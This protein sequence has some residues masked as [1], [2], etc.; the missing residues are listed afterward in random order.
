MKKI[1]TSLKAA[2]AVCV[3][4]TTTSLTA[5]G[6]WNGTGD[7]LW[8]NSANWSV[9]PYPLGNDTASFINAGN[10]QNIDIAGLAGI[11]N[12]TFDSPLVAAYTNGT[13]APNS[14]TL[15]LAD[16]GTITLTGTALNSQLF[17]CGL[18]LGTTIGAGAY[19]L[20]NGNMAQTLTF[21]NVFAPAGGAA[22]G[23]K[24]LAINGAGNTTILGNISKGGATSL[25]LTH[26]SSG[27]LTL[28]GSNVITT[29]TMNGGTNSVIDIGSGTLF[30]NNLGTIVLNCNQGGVINGT[31]K[32][33]LSTVDGFNN[34][35][36]NYADLN[37]AA[38]KTLVI[39]PEITGLGGFE[40]NTGTGTFVLNGMN[41]F[42]GHIFLNTASPISVFRIGNRG[43]VDSNLGKGSIIYFN[44][45]AKLIYTGT[46]ET[47]DR[48]IILNNTG[49]IDQSGP[50]GKLS[51]SVSP[52]ILG[53]N[54]TLILQ[55]STACS[56]E[57]TAPLVN[58]GYTLTVTKAGS[59]TWILSGTN[60]YTGNT[61]VNGG[62]LLVNA[63]GTST[64]SSITVNNGAILGGNSTINGNVTL[65]AGGMLAPGD[66]GTVGT[67]NLGG[68][69]T[70]T[71]GTLLF[72]VSN[73]ATDKVSVVGALTVNG[74]NTVVLSFPSGTLPAGTNT[75]MTFA[76]RTG[77]GTFVLSPAY[78]NATLLTN[79]TSVQ[80]VVSDTGTYSKIWKG[81][82]SGNWNTTE[83]NWTN[84]SAAV[85]FVA[86]DA[87]LFD[88]SAL[89]FNVTSSSPVLPSAVLFNNNVSNYVLSAAMAGTGVVFKTGS[90]NVT[91]S[92]TNTF[93]G[94]TTIVAGTLTI[95]ETGVLGNGNYATNI[96]N[97]GAVNYASSIAQTNSGVISGGG[98][99]TSSGSGTLTLLGANTYAGPT[100][101][102]AGVL[103][104]QNAAGLGTTAE[105]TTVA[106]GAKLE[107][108]GNITTLG[109]TLN[110][111]GTLASQTGTNTYAGVVSLQAGSFLDV[112]LNSLLI[113]TANTAN[114]GV[115]PFSKTGAGTLRL[116]GDPNHLGVFTVSAGTLELTGGGNA[117]D[118]FVID[119]G[120]TLM[121]TTANLGD[122]RLT[123]NGLFD[124]RATDQ[125]GGLDGS[126]IVTIGNTTAYTFTVGGNN[127]SGVFSGVM[128][129]GSGTLSFAKVQTGIQTL[130]GASTYSGGTTLSGGQLNINNGGS[131]GTSSAIGT[132]AFTISGAYTIDN[133]SGA[134]V[135]LSPVIAQS[136]NGSFTFVGSKSLN[137]GTGAVTMNNNRAV[138]VLT[139][140]LTVGGAIGGGAYSLTKA[141]AGT[142]TLSGAN[143]YS[144]A[145]IVN[146]G[147]LIINGS[148]VAA[149]AV[150]VN[151][152]TILGGSG[153]I[154][155]TV[156]VAAGGILAPG[157]VNATNTL[158]LTNTGNALTLTN[159]VLLFDLPASGT[160]CDKINITGATGKL[161]LNGVNKIA[162]SFP[163]G[164]AQAG[165]YILMTCTGGIT[166]NSGVGLTLQTVYPGATLNM[167]GNNL[168]LTLGS[169]ISGVT[170]KG[171]LSDVWD[172]GILNWTTN[173][174]VAASYTAGNVVTF[175]DTATGNFS[176]S[177]VGTVSP[178]SVLFNNSVNDYF[179]TADLSGTG[180]LV[181]WGS[182]T[183]TLLSG[184]ST[185]NPISITVNDGTLALG[186]A[187]RL[188]SGVY[189]GNILNNGMLT[190]ASSVAQTNS[191]ILSG[192]GTL[193]VSGSGTLTLSGTNTYTGSTIVNA[194][195]TLA[196]AGNISTPAGA[197]LNLFGTLSSPTGSNTYVGAVSFQTGSA[198]DVGLGSILTLS[199]STVLVAGYPPFTKT[200]AGL[201][202]LMTD[203]NHNGTMTINGGAVELAGA[204]TDGDYVIN[205]G[206]TLIESIVN[207]INDN[208]SVT[209]NAG[210]FYDL[211]QN[212]TIASFSGA[213]TVTKGTTGGATL[214][215]GGNNQSCTFSGVIENGLGMLSYVKTG[216][217][218]QTLTGMNSYTGTT[219][220][221]GG[222]LLVNSPGSLSNSTVTVNAACTLGGNGSINGNVIMSTG[223]ILAPGG[224]NAFG[225]LTLGR[226]LTLNGNTLFFDVSS[227]ATEQVVVTGVLTNKGVNTI[228]LSFP[229]GALPAADYTL[230]TFSSKVDTGSFV[231]LGSY[232]N[233]SLVFVGNSLVLRVSGDGTSGLTWNGNVSASWDGSDKNW[234][235]GTS[236]TNFAAG[237]AVTFDDTASSFNVIS[238]GVVTPSS[239]FFNNNID[240]PYF[241]TANIDGTALLLKAGPGSTTL[242]ALSTYNPTSI[243]VNA[244]TL[245]LAGASQL[246]S[247]NCS[248]PI[249]INSGTFNHSSSAAQILSGIISGAGSVV[250][251]VSGSLTLSN[252]NTYSGNTTLSGGTLYGAN[253][254]AFGTAART[255]S[256]GGGTLDLATDTSINA[257]N[258]TVTASTTI[259]SD[260]ATASSA[261]IT[262][263]LG[264]LST[265]NF[266]LYVKS[267][268]NVSANSSYGLTFGNT[269]L[270]ANTPTFDVAN[271][272]TGL[273][274][275]TLGA[276]SNNNNFNKANS[277]TLFLGTTSARAG[278]TA[279]ITAGTLKLGHASALG[280]TAALLA[281]NGGTLDLAIDT[282][283]NAHPTTVGGNTTIQSDKAT[284]SSAGITHTLGTLS[285]GAYTLS[286][287]PG[288]NVSANSSY[289]L[290]FGIATLTGNAVFSVANNGTG[291]G[292]LTLGAVSG[293]FNLTKSGTGILALP[294]ANT[295]SGTTTV[296]G[297]TLA[298]STANGVLTSSTAYT[299][300]SGG[301]L[302]LDNTSAANNTNRLRDASAITLD[303]GTLCFTNNGG[304]TTSYRENA[305][306][307]FVTNSGG[308][309]VSAQAA[310]GMTNILS[311][312]ALTR[313]G[314]APLNFV[315]AG[316]GASDRNR[317]FI[318]GQPN[319]FIGFWATINT[320]NYAAYD[321]NLGVIVAGSGVTFTNILA[322]GPSII[323]DDP[324]LNAWINEEGTGGGITLAAAYTN[325]IKSLVQNTDWLATVAMTNQTLLVNEVVVSA[326]TGRVL[327]LGTAV[328]EGAVA[329]LSAGGELLLTAAAADSVLTV[330][331]AVSN[332]T[333]A[334]TVTKT[335]P[336]TVILA[337]TN[338]IGGAKVNKGFLTLAKT[339]SLTSGTSVTAGSDTPGTL[340]IDGGTLNCGGNNLQ[341]GSAA[342]HLGAIYL[343]SG[344]VTNI[345]Q[346]L[347]GGGLNT[348]N[349]GFLKI[350]GGTWS[351]PN[352]GAN[353]R[354]RIGQYGGVGL[355]YQTNG[356]YNAGAQAFDIAN[357]T[358]VN[359]GVV[360]L[361]GSGL[362]NHNG[363]LVVGGTVSSIGSLGVLTMADMAN[364]IFNGSITIGGTAGIL[365][366]ANLN[367]GTLQ[368][369]SVILSAAGL[370][371]LNGGTLKAGAAPT[372]F[373][374]GS[375][376]ALVFTKGV[377]VDT[378]AN[379][380]TVG[381]SLLAPTG[382][383]VVTIPVL[384]Y[385]SG[386][387]GA[388]FVGINGDGGGATAIA[389][390][391]DDGTGNGTYKIQSLTLTS[392]GTNYTQ[393]TSVTLAGGGGS[394]T[395]FDTAGVTFA[396]NVS[397]GLTKQGTG[398]LILSGTNTYAGATTISN[399]T[400]RLGIA[401]AL[402]FNSVVN[403]NG[404]IYD[405]GGFTVTNGA[406]NVTSG[407]IINGMLASSS[408]TVADSATIYASLTGTNGFTK[409]GN[410]TLVVS[411][412]A[413]DFTTGP[414]V[415]NGGTL[416][417]MSGLPT[418]GLSYWL[419]AADGSKI[420]TPSGSNVTAWADSF[421]NGVNF[422]Q[423]TPANQ[424]VYVANAI[425]G[426]PAVRFNGTS[427]KMVASKAANAQTVFIVNKVNARADLDGI[428][429]RNAID[430]GIRLVSA[431]AW[432]NPG[433]AGDF[434]YN[435]GQI[436]VN[437][438]LNNNFAAS[439]P[440]VLTAISAN[441][442]V[443]WTTA[444]GEYYNNSTRWYNGDIG[445]LLVY[446]SILS[447]NDRQRV[448]SYLM[449]KWLGGSNTNQPA[450][451]S[452]VLASGTLL[453]L[454]GQ[455]LT[456]AG[457]S[458][459]GT[460][461]NGTL[462]VTG[463]ISPAGTNVIGTLTVKADTTL[464]GKLVVDL[465]ANTSDLLDVQGNLTLSSPML[466]IQNL[467]GLS[468]SKIYTLATCSGTI[469]GSFASTNIT[470]TR[471]AVH[472]TENKVQLYFKNGTLIRI[473]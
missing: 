98:S 226:S 216:T 203:P 265:G 64:G 93:N 211:R 347:I 200:G 153:T 37:V 192:A 112:G 307:L 471:W 457:L 271:N 336:G 12:I 286:V 34:L 297:G 253:V 26:N 217:G 164:A 51:F 239:V 320:T 213:G 22:A 133:T 330:N 74:T 376:R 417:L 109:E 145:T 334:S 144:G 319:G 126:G 168:V 68:T 90:G 276:L 353:P 275:L 305:G 391:A 57:F 19:T 338:N 331:A 80:L 311:L 149:S 48:Q 188:N 448:E 436:Y 300:T 394:G 312:G 445:E 328:N 227:M 97:N 344:L 201:L 426:R 444:I 423:G 40:S 435:G 463:S 30:L 189:A 157:G 152:G 343:N 424:P 82:N 121:E 14:Q 178:A 356:A 360:Y 11:Q 123:D 372:T 326:G 282:S 395:T 361:A 352:T 58:T 449:A 24:T 87:V 36:Y 190:F 28:A 169:D 316:L 337:G 317:I 304:A 143:T 460:V 301:T 404:G 270:A 65:T 443:G 46:G 114:I 140:T 156:N 293:A 111:F 350:S 285:M 154:N 430:T 467:Q 359:T 72:D 42:E 21:N 27:T 220:V 458:G 125:I 351:Q 177:S 122:Y 281:L 461:S 290:T 246:N 10:G 116:T 33:R 107:L 247:G 204:M 398:M 92:G 421:T 420:T 299:I 346:N 180:P 327:T 335:G 279:T 171:S 405:L 380:M 225:T 207:A 348:P 50:S 218:I 179:I 49:T 399:G 210:G 324:T 233:A 77:T 29:L 387:I 388:P 76:S 268:P 409:N 432:N 260:K 161:V 205:N 54:R 439:T 173:G 174:S 437:G 306:A 381:Q 455:S 389:N 413:G 468:T 456:F 296:N 138:T 101:V 81:N 322:K 302:L 25:T 442:V 119:A 1:L 151:T 362:I 473:M 291:L 264:T 370:L 117:D 86:G 415:V 323:P 71:S 364:A 451:G 128:Q 45:T 234:E 79:A 402:P 208:N 278:G 108:A 8:T 194:G 393:I 41:T 407:S 9:S 4:A 191:G 309:I 454:D 266:T 100:T 167:V 284:A 303:N 383:G 446:N 440:H 333:T 209:I 136:W 2:L 84:N 197:P 219:T 406:V 410:G 17:N 53:G 115:Q 235:I 339:G 59:G 186:G 89:I 102:N 434:T 229:D 104:I 249:A 105:G 44:N 212:D 237:A 244:G 66:V 254:S 230:M 137:L 462:T 464:S 416:K 139:N 228:A 429:G 70:L 377:T 257:H 182:D 224:M 251:A 403:V 371:N 163:Y 272:G 187:S 99:L 166:T 289:G 130:S 47:S 329:P 242:S 470:D 223:G 56:G 431:T 375:G 341:T 368:V 35:T 150:T 390:M 294:G 384:T 321:S 141:G 340:T 243:T 43:S 438:A 67:L 419:D 365:G 283:V 366:F 3:C 248:V 106:A 221:S 267:G 15:I 433:S 354:H 183:A 408:L 469:S 349:Y 313:T 236:A 379:S 78:V 374:A 261:G 176:V 412:T 96:I 358:G 134:D 196:L 132:G 199:A 441:Q 378:Q 422:A 472:T 69:L 148:T 6:I 369:T 452:V 147:T 367:G 113:L 155:G 62:K 325:R 427:Q 245:V 202:K 232:P 127:Q 195:A 241:V 120:A 450:G 110:L 193:I 269:T 355:F 258:T 256:L 184:V 332:N 259:Q 52:T 373:S 63:P 238:S 345:Q 357:A 252:A 465:N 385:G 32:I 397:G 172:N 162:L 310:V 250:K 198:I 396:A 170:W 459:S 262:H 418:V 39:N 38:G 159:S 175:D 222:T 273:G 263:T 292:T 308:T 118:A 206:G 16:N 165:D 231:L 75:L 401:N 60:T 160:A 280:T 55:G 7:A 274:T 129:N 287:T 288:A 240:N 142:L 181:K 31:G 318:A 392:P 315:A 85:N 414:L 23:A 255:L 135:T 61:T 425:N 5:N 83:P 386:Y 428:W 131:G 88:D 91:L 400:I 277:G 382:S 214:T 94:Q 124:L 185:Y 298:L 18:Q 295:Y 342:G 453:D 363:A 13:G 215:A 447:T 466:E 73:V 411:R 20:T 158:T 95:S 103:K 146:G 314:S